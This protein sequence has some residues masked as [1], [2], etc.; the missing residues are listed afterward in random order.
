VAW[1]R[2]PIAA[3]RRLRRRIDPVVFRCGILIVL[4]LS[5]FDM[6]RRAVG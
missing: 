1:H 6:L 4:A 5:G 3:G 2:T